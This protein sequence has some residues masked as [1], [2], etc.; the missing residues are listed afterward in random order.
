MA[1]DDKLKI[2]PDHKKVLEHSRRVIDETR[3]MVLRL[4]IDIENQEK[5][6]ARQ[7]EAMDKMLRDLGIKDD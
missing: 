7:R 5:I 3:K 2:N 6:L 1:D 4:K